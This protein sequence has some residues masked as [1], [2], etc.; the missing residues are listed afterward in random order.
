MS[1]SVRDG[2]IMKNGPWAHFSFWPVEWSDDWSETSAEYVARSVGGAFDSGRERSWPRT[3]GTRVS[4]ATQ[5]WIA[6]ALHRSFRRRDD[7]RLRT[8][9]PRREHGVGCGGPDPGPIHF[10]SVF[11]G[12]GS[13]AAHP[14]TFCALCR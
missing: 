8:S 12:I 10:G 2:R 11:A 7:R 3:L 14:R 5:W 9:E 13:S 1:G 4:H 6:Q